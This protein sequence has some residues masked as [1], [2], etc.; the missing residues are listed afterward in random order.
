MIR[1]EPTEVAILEEESVLTVAFR[2]SGENQIDHVILSRDL[3]PTDQDRT[4]GLDRLYIEIND[5]N[6]GG[7]QQSSEVELS[8]NSVQIFPSTKGTGAQ[9]GWSAIELTGPE[10]I[11]NKA[12]IETAVK[13]LKSASA[14]GP[15][16]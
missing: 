8:R 11:R 10:I 12:A 9:E 13:R 14:E 7:Y 1:I 16:G 4:L 15:V 5:Q 6:S 2:C 3:C